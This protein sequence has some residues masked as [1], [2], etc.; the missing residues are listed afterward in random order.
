[1]HG[2]FRPVLLGLAL[3]TAASSVAAQSASVASTSNATVIGLTGLI[4]S[5]DAESS[6]AFG[7]SANTGFSIAG[8]LDI[9]F[10]YGMEFTTDPG[11]QRTDV[12]MTYAFTPLKQGGSAP[13]SVH[14][15]GTYTYRTEESDFLRTARLEREGQGYTLGFLLA[16][17]LRLA[18]AVA[19]RLAAVGRHSLFR[20]VTGLTFAYDPATYVGPTPVDYGQY[21]QRETTSL[22]EYG[23]YAAG[24]FDFPSGMTLLAGA[25]VLADELAR[26]RVQPQIQVLFPR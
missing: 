8:V 6:G 24:L 7:L 17:D 3:L 4:G 16:H 22:F 25:L 26:V 12:G 18:D 10:L 2:H 11:S 21:P 20:D 19:F 23:A 5:G 9:G 1:M 13:V 14:V 15:F